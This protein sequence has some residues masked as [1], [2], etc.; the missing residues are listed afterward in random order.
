M[1][2]RRLQTMNRCNRVAV[3][4]GPR[5]R[6]CVDQHAPL[7]GWRTKLRGRTHRLGTEPSR[8]RR[9]GTTSRRS[10]QLVANGICRDLVCN[11]LANHERESRTRAPS[12]TS[13]ARSLRA[14]RCT[15]RWSAR[16]ARSTRRVP[17]RE[18]AKRAERAYRF[19]LGLRASSFIQPGHLDRLH[20]GL[21]AGELLAL[22]LQA[23]EASYLGSTGASTE[24]TGCQEAGLL[25]AGGAAKLIAVVHRAA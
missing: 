7:A 6:M 9:R 20:S 18:L 3:M 19:E 21:L 15:A 8:M 12:R 2:G 25:T 5:S 10:E 17:G 24:L 22:Q 23:T 16:S 13:S 14:A 11:D 4:I 1:N